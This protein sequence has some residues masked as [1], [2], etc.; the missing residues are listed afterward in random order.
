MQFITQI[1][2]EKYKDVVIGEI[3]SDVLVLTDNQCEHIIKRRGE[4]FYAKYHKYFHVIAEDPDFIFA[5]SSHENTAI[6]CKSFE[7]GSKSINLVIKLA[8]VGDDIE[9]ENSIITAVVENEKRYR[10]RLRNKIPLYKKE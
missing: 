2:I 9:L 10:Q 3:R 6:A 5:D 1:D 8:I 4:S 7:E